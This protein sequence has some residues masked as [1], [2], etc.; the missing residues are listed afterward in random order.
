MEKDLLPRSLT[1]LLTEF[2][3]LNAIDLRPSG[4]YWLESTLNFLP[5]HR[6]AHNMAACFITVSKWGREQESPRETEVTEMT[7]HR[8]L[9]DFHLLK[10]SH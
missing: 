10:V 6:A 9:A 2:S 5:F 8:F 4:D 7:S 1:W 3:S